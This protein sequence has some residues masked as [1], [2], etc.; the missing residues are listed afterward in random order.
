[1]PKK[2]LQPVSKSSTS[3]PWSSLETVLFPSGRAYRVKSPVPAE[4]TRLSPLTVTFPLSLYHSP[5]PYLYFLGS[6][7]KEPTQ[8]LVSVSDIRETQI[9]RNKSDLMVVLRIK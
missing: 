7:H 2:H 1:M 8:F 3:S 4:A 9:T 6:P 5:T